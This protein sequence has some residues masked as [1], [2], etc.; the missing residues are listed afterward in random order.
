MKKNHVTVIER[1]EAIVKVLKGKKRLK[2]VLLADLRAFVKKHID[3]K[4]STARRKSELL[5]MVEQY[6]TADTLLECAEEL[7]LFGLALCDLSD[8]LDIS[9]KQANKLV[10][11]GTLTIL[12]SICYTYNPCT[13]YVISI[14][15]AV[16]AEVAG[17]L[18]HTN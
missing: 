2:H 12:T 5:P 7:P 14:K 17:L 6:L 18:D 16:E 15:D 8:A 13:I 11:S 10:K 9:K 1:K 4:V 3:P